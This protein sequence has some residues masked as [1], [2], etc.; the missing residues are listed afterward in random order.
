MPIT[1]E[2]V[3]ETLPMPGLS[4]MTT[5]PAVAMIIAAAAQMLDAVAEK[6]QAEQRHLHRLGLDIG[7]SDDEGALAH[8]RQ[9]GRG[10]ADLRQRAEHH[11]RPE[12]SRRVRQ[13]VAAEIDHARQK[14][15][16]RERKAEQKTHMRRAD[17]AERRR[18][19]ALH[20]IA[21]GLRRGGDE[22]KDGPEHVRISFQEG[23]YLRVPTSI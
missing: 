14:D 3:V 15:E 8:H 11:P 18:Q 4:E 12:N 17:G 2:R 1:V 16:Q 9:H 5:T 19:F 7:V 10:G 13:A 6:D 23:S 21:R 20:G 22:G